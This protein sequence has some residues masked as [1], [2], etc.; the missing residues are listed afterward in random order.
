VRDAIYAGS[1]SMNS[2]DETPEQVLQRIFDAYEDRGSPDRSKVSADL[3]SN[4]DDFW[5][6]QGNTSELIFNDAVIVE[7]R[8]TIIVTHF[9]Y[10]HLALLR[11]SEDNLWRLEAIIPQCPACFSTGILFDNICCG[12]CGGT[13]WG[14]LGDLD[15]LVPH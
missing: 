4:F 3:A 8:A 13:G 6:R 14:T 2:I 5:L 12:S 1:Q 11:Q 9:G 10:P 15:F 7:S